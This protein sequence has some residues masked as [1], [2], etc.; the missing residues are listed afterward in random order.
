MILLTE[1]GDFSTYCMSYTQIDTQA[2]TCR[3][4]GLVCEVVLIQLQWWTPVMF[5]PPAIDCGSKFTAGPCSRCAQIAIYGRRIG[6]AATVRSDVHRVIR[7][8][9]A[10]ADE[11]AICGADSDLHL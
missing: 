6:I 10:R 8:L 2:S 5:A 4:E 1:C 7:H 11:V 3:V 9:L